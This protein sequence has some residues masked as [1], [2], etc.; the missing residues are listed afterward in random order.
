MLTIGPYLYKRVGIN[1]RVTSS[2]QNNGLH[3]KKPSKDK[4]CKILT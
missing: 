3:Q 1:L 2:S 4:L